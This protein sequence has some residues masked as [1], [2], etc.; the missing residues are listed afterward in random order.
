MRA[1][2]EG[3]LRPSVLEV[4]KELSNRAAS[5]GRGESGQVPS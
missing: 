2:E 1:V 3:G 4:K 5:E